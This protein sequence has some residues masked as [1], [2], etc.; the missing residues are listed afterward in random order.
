MSAKNEHKTVIYIDE[1]WTKNGD[2]DDIIAYYTNPNNMKKYDIQ[3]LTTGQ[4]ENIPTHQI[5]N[6]I[7][8][9]HTSI[10][11]GHLRAID[12]EVAKNLIP[13]TY[14]PAFAKFFKREIE[15]ITLDILRDKYLAND[16]SRFIKPL[17]NSK[18]FNGQ[19]IDDFGDL[20]K[21]FDEHPELSP[22][23]RV[24]S[25]PVID[26]QGEIRLLIGSGHLYGSGQISVA[27][28]PNKDYLELSTSSIGGVSNT[29]VL[30]KLITA[31]GDRFLCVDIG[32]VP[33][34][35]RWVVVEINPPF[36]L[37]DYDIPLTDY[38][39]FTEDAFH[40]IREKLP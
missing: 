7:V 40:W 32:W 25:A 37:E 13:N 12:P 6:G 11:Q 27:N 31:T 20:D 34:L 38:L 26:I 3:I 15:I 16:E 35:E 8:F 30:D 18:S 33:E 4:L 29:S 1:E 28:P 14:D 23:T 39:R 36:S 9:A 21:L 2:T 5:L 22:T 10:I 17:G 24:Y 19:V